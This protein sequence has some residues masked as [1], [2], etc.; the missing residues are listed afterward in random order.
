[1]STTS[2]RIG[3]ACL[4][5][6]ERAAFADWMRAADLEP[7]LLVEACLV[8]ANVAGKGLECV[9]ADA[10]L[11]RREYLAEL[12][13]TDPRL[14]IIAVGEVGDP[15]QADL[16]R[17]EVRFVARPLDQRALLLAV[18]LA[19]AEGRP[20]RRSLRR[21][22]PRLPSKIDGANAILLDVSGEGLRVEVQS[23]QGARLAPM[24]H[25]Q[26]PMFKV[27]VTV[28]RI[29]VAGSPGQGKVQCG[30]SLLEADERAI[31]TWRALIDHVGSPT[32]A[33]Q[34]RPQPAKVEHDR[35]LGRLGQFLADAPVLG[36]ALS[37]RPGRPS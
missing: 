11:L 21:V 32:A 25:V 22:V 15:S 18:S 30:A 9:I 3:V 28:R 2:P 23:E 27:G 7:V 1:M 29:W 33:H 19:M 20:S 10:A 4:H 13:R 37:W 6:S 35:F 26:V 34:F 5:P 12:R 24:F 8:N 16:E 31:R 14:P 36:S 17:R